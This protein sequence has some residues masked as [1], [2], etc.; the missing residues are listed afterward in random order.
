MKTFLLPFIIAMLAVGPALADQK[1][2]V[3]DLKKCGSEAANAFGKHRENPAIDEGNGYVGFET[4]ESD[5][6]G[7]HEKY[8]LVN[9]ATRKLVQVNAEYLLKDSSKG[10]PGHGDLFAHVDALRSKKKLANEDLF[11]KNAQRGGYE[12]VKGQLAKAYTP[13]ASRGDCGCSLYYPETMP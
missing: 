5:A 4:D 6:G 11:V 1:Q 12:V 9:C 3:R 7:T 8:T 10:L 2:V 13:K